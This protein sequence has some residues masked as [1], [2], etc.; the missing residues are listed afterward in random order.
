M[1]DTSHFNGH[2]T[3]HNSQFMFTLH[4]LCTA[5]A[6]ACDS[7]A[8]LRRSSLL[9]E[10]NSVHPDS[11]PTRSESDQFNVNGTSRDTVTDSLLVFKF[12]FVFSAY[13]SFLIMSFVFDSSW[14]DAVYDVVYDVYDVVYDVVVGF[15]SA[16]VHVSFK[17]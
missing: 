10:K 17:S 12:L 14:D 3:T 9:E 16:T 15:T 4:S 13:D 11:T 1:F 6:F 2:F 8:Q 5:P 7:R